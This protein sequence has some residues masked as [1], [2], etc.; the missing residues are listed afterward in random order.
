MR[1][2]LASRAIA[3]TSASVGRRSVSRSVATT[4]GL[5]SRQVGV[6]KSCNMFGSVNDQKR[7]KSN[8][9]KSN[10]KGEAG[11]PPPLGANSGL[12]RLVRTRRTPNDPP[13]Y[14]AAASVSG[15]T[16]TNVRPLALA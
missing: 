16:D 10:E 5:G 12:R 8:D 6:E 15:S 11:F 13:Y 4:L 9:I 3:F 14:S 7:F 1:R 2:S